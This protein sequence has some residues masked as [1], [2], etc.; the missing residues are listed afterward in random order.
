VPDFWD[1]L[2]LKVEKLGAH[3]SGDS[4][5][6]GR[7]GPI[8][9]SCGRTGVLYS[10]RSSRNTLDFSGSGKRSSIRGPLRSQANLFL[11]SLPGLPSNTHESEPRSISSEPAVQL[12]LRNHSDSKKSPLPAIIAAFPWTRLC[13]GEDGASLSIE[14]HKLA[15]EWGGKSGGIANRIFWVS[16]N[17]GD[18]GHRFLA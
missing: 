6:I 12:G 15:E 2:Q 13:G 17:L 11:P 8:R 3:I 4:S 10:Q 14:K 1:K 5:S 9:S 7:I 16:R 18:A